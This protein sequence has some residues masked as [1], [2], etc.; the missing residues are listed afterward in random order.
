MFAAAFTALKSGGVFG[1]VEHRKPG[2]PA[3]TLRPQAAIAPPAE[4]HVI[5]A[6]RA[7]GFKLAG[8]S[9][10]NANPRTRP[11]MPVACGACRRKGART[12]SVTS[13]SAATG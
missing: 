1:V 10:V 6:G 5:K 8:R 12:A 2:G 7:A 11:T 9:E 3:P 13:P 4:A